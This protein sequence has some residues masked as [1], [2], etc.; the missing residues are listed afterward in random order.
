MLGVFHFNLGEWYAGLFVQSGVNK[1]LK[2]KAKQDSGYLLDPWGYA[3]QVDQRSKCRWKKQPAMPTVSAYSYATVEHPK[4]AMATAT[5]SKPDLDLDL[6][7]DN[8]KQTG[9]VKHMTPLIDSDPS[10]GQ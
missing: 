7:L 3:S 1:T 9:K 5:A 6:D 2:E 8:D 4:T 10:I